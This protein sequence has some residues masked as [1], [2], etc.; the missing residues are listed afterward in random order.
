L[1]NFLRPSPNG[2]A[3]DCIARPTGSAGTILGGISTYMLAPASNTPI[4]MTSKYRI[5]IR[6][7]TTLGCSAQKL[8]RNFSPVFGQLCD[9]FF[10]QPHIH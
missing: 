8:L 2:R 10:V 6:H 7:S 4:R 5:D 9:Y 3:P 1:E